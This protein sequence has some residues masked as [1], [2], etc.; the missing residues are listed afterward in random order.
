MT[1]ETF[2]TINAIL[3]TINL[4]NLWFVYKDLAEAKKRAA[5]AEKRKDQLRLLLPMIEETNRENEQRANLANARA[6]R[7]EAALARVEAE[8]AKTGKKPFTGPAF[9][10]I[11]LAAAKIRLIKTGTKPG[12]PNIDLAASRIDRINIAASASKAA[13]S[14]GNIPKTDTK[15][16]SA[17]SDSLQALGEAATTEFQRLLAMNTKGG[18]S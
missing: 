12:S 9:S 17:L 14:A 13:A 7:A 6:D 15:S 16:V 2:Y 11:D 5:A 3:W 4:I 8:I 1:Y 10:N 18:Q